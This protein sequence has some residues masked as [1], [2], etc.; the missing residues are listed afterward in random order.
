MTQSPFPFDA[1]ILFGSLSIML[2]IGVI[3]RAKITFFQNFLIPSCLIGGV[4]GLI[5]I[6]S[7]LILGSAKNLETFAYHFFNISFISV[8]LTPGNNQKQKRIRKKGVLRGPLWMT[9]AQTF[10]FSL[11]PSSAV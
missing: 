5:L 2:L 9:L 10:C 11:Q 4:L 6:N 8:G 1:M 3:L 7:G